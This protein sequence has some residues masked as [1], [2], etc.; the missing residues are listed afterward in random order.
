MN[1]KQ[2]DDQYVAHTYKR[3]PLCIT[4]GEG[5]YVFDEKGNAFL[6]CTSGIG[7]NALGYAHPIWLKAVCDQ[8]TGLGHISNLYYTTPMLELAKKLCERTNMKKVFYANSGAEANE[9][10]LKV[11]RKYANT[12]YNGVRDTILTLTNSF[13]GRTMNTLTATGQDS[14]HQHFNPFMHGFD[15]IKTNNIE[16][17]YNKVNERTAAIMIEVVQGEGGVIALQED[18]M[19]EIQSLCTQKDILF[20]IDE[21]QSGIGRC[22]TLFAYEQ[23][24]LQPDI[25]SSAK[26]LGNGLPIGACLLSEKVEET[27]TY[28][29]HG[30]TFGANPVACA[31]ANVVLDILDE[32]F[33]QEV[34]Q[35]AN[36]L[37]KQLL[38]LPKVNAVNGLGLMVGVVLDGVNVQDVIAQGMQHNVLLL[39]A[40]ENLR[41]LPPLTITYEEIDKIISVLKDI[42][43]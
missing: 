31:G 27:L 17:L 34:S 38:S 19:K 6:D 28:G 14:F 13:H 29:D 32:S 30:T 16:D 7:V 5:N 8:V 4:K 40:K 37:K 42:L 33:L 21:I 36:Y 1:Y 3:F 25:V 11:A 43:Q 24:Q 26:G 23:F 41:L 9:A 18:F 2:L 35:K 22:G 12:K 39:S 15:Y 10:C 20:I